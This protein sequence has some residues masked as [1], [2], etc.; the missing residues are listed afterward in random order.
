MKDLECA[1]Y[2]GYKVDRLG[3]VYSKRTGNKMSTVIAKDGTE[4]ITI[5]NDLGKTKFVFVHRLVAIAFIPNVHNK[6]QVDHI[7]GNKQNNKVEN[8]RWCTNVENQEYRDTQGNSGKD[9]VNKKIKWGTE[10]YSSIK[11]LAKVIATLRG[12]KVSTVAKELKAVRYGPKMLYG[13]YCELVV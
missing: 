10:V 7:D 6:P 2:T 13:N 5:V 3:C 12:S 9:R 8:L 1:G 11:G 4:K